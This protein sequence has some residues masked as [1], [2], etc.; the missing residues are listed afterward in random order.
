MVVV[1]LCGSWR[2]IEQW[3]ALAR[4]QGLP[5]RDYPEQSDEPYSLTQVLVLDGEVV[6]DGG[7]PE[8]IR[9]ASLRLVDALDHDLLELRFD[10]AWRFA[11]AT[12][13]PALTQGGQSR[14]AAV[15]RALRARAS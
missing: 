15:A 12:L 11:D 7:A 6:E 14:V 1:P 9:Q 13:M 8:Q 3:R 4:E 2:S 5:I 10:P